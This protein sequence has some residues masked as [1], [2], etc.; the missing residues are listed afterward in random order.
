MPDASRALTQEGREQLR[1]VLRRARAA[2]AAPSLILN[3]PYVRA[4]QTA[5]IAAEVLGYQGR[6]VSTPALLPGG[7]PEGVWAELRGRADEAAILAVGHEP[8]LSHAVS[9][10]LGASSV[11]VVMRPAT[12]AGFRVERL[13]GEPRGLLEW[14]FGPALA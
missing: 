7:E 3:S 5:E 9:S 14:L 13:S 2:G 12:L 10:L 1:R 4:V 6:L 11:T 8:L